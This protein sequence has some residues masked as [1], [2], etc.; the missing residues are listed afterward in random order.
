[1]GYCF[2]ILEWV[3]SWTEFSVIRPLTLSLLTSSTFYL[4]VLISWIRLSSKFCFRDV[5]SY[6]IRW[7]FFFSS[8]FWVF[9]INCSSIIIL[10]PRLILSSRN[11]VLFKLKVSSIFRSLIFSLRS[12][13]VFSNYLNLS[14]VLFFNAEA[15]F[16]PPYSY[17][18][19]FLPKVIYSEGIW[20]YTYWNS[21]YSYA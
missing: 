10:K 13:T 15:N 4:I 17:S 12:F 21:W 8:S 20:P 3:W 7:I 16:S 11:L 1:M 18:E 2:P 19:V 5:F 6:E 14:S 9:R